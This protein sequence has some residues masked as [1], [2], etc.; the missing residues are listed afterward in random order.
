M[1]T[2]GVVEKDEGIERNFI[3]VCFSLEHFY[4]SSSQTGTEKKKIKNFKL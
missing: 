1:A 4:G 3:R 2:E